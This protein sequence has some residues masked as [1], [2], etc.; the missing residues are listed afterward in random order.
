MGL[1]Y[2]I[3]RCASVIIAHATEKQRIDLQVPR[4]VT[5]TKLLVIDAETTHFNLRLV[6]Q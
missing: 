3:P 1:D 2:L 5:T 6:T 4:T